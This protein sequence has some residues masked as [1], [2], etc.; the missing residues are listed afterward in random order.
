MTFYELN[1]SV[2]HSHKVIHSRYI[3][4]F[5]SHIGLLEIKKS[6][7]IGTAVLILAS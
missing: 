4:S 5:L 1:N 2:L 7:V 3:I 6:L